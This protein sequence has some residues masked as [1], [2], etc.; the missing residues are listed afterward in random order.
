MILKL[1]HITDHNLRS[2]DEL[3]RNHFLRAVAKNMKGAGEPTWDYEGALGDGTMDLSMR[4][5]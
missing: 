4:D 3:F 1:N 5:I 2:L